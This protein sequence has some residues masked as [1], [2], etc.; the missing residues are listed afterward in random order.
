MFST[1]FGHTRPLAGILVGNRLKEGES[2]AELTE[3]LN[4]PAGM[5]PHL[6]ITVG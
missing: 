5:V 6:H 1:I 4:A 3:A 2:V